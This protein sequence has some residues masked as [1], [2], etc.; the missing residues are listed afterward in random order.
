MSI[1]DRDP[2]LPTLQVSSMHGFVPKEKTERKDIATRL[3]Q[4]PWLLAPTTTEYE[5]S[6]RFFFVRQD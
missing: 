1:I 5:P 2:R 3:D 4:V 6:F